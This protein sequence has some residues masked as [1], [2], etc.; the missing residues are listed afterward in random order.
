MI[1]FHCSDH[2]LSTFITMC[3]YQCDKG[4][5]KNDTGEVI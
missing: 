3:G 5:T 4:V 2:G 1:S